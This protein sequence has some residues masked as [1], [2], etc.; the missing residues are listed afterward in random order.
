[1]QRVYA[2]RG[3]ITVDTD[4]REAVITRTQTLLKEL[5]GRNAIGS[6]D[7]V[8]IVFTATGDIHAEFPAAA[9]RLM[10]LGGIPLLCARELDVTSSLAVERCIRVLVHCYA[11]QRPE[12]VYLEGAAGLLDP[13]DPL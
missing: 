2:V 4:T 6:E 3:A 10:G 1:M 11:D 7:I 12:P 9:A 5:L 13:P 8:G